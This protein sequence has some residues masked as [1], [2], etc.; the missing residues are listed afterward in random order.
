MDYYIV[1]IEIQIFEPV[2]F[3]ES[4]RKINCG[5]TGCKNKKIG[6]NQLKIHHLRKNP[7]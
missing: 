6:R 7:F 4:K 1:E 5:Q 3:I 2:F